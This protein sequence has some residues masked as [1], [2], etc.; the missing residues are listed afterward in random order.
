MLACGTS[1]TAN[2]WQC[3]RG[4]PRRWTSPWSHTLPAQR[5]I[6]R[7]EPQV[8]VTAGGAKAGAMEEQQVSRS[9]R[10]GGKAG[11]NLGADPYQDQGVLASVRGGVRRHH[12]WPKEVS[13][14]KPPRRNQKGCY[15][16]D[17]FSGRGGVALACERIG[18]VS[19]QWDIRLGH[20]CDLT[21]RNVLYRL[22]CDI[23]SGKVLAM[24]MAPPRQFFFSGP[25]S[26]QGDSNTEPAMGNFV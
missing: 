24:M 18:F 26:N 3:S 20:Q 4:A 22:K 11:S 15:V 9:L 19:R 25:R 1:T 13:K 16:A 23:R 17:V 10:E 8:P 14:F 21:S 7:P 2:T 12:D 6:H 5:P